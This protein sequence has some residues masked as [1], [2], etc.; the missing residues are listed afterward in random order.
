VDGG[1]R[2]GGGKGLGVEEGGETKVIVKMNY[3]TKK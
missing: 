3:L 2:G 1:W